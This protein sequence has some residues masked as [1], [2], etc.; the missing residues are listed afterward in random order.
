MT[1]AAKGPIVIVGAGQAGGRAAEASRSA[2][3]G[4][5]VTLIGRELHPSYESMSPAR[6]LAD[7]KRSARAA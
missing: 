4:G 3:Y 7:L 1:V 5:P 2:G 6:I